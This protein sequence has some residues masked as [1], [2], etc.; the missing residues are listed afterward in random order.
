MLMSRWG[1][2]FTAPALEWRVDPGKRPAVGAR[3]DG[4]PIGAL[5]LAIGTLWLLVPLP[6]LLGG[7]PFPIAD[8]GRGGPYVSLLPRHRAHA[9]GPADPAAPPD[10]P[11]R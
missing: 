1:S 4:Q 10:H 8:L 11:D 3:R 2:V 6:A 9:M 7:A 5:I